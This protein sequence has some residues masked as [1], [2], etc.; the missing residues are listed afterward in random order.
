MDIKKKL[1]IITGFLGAGKTTF[2]NRLPEIFPYEKYA[3]IINEFGDKSVDHSL[4]KDNNINISKVT[5]GSIFCV[6]RQDK[7]VDAL[8]ALSKTDSKF[9]F[10]ET[11]GM[12]D[13]LKMEKILITAQKL[14]NNA[15]LYSGCISIADSVSFLKVYH[16]LNAVKN[17]IISADAVLINKS[18]L[19]DESS[20]IEIEK[21]ILSLNPL[22]KV[23]R[24]NFCVPDDNSILIN[25]EHKNTK[26]NYIDLSSD[27]YRSFT[28]ILDNSLP[29]DKFKKWT[30]LILKYAFRIKGFAVLDN[31]I[32]LIDCIP[33]IINI[34][35]LN[36]EIINKF[37]II[38]HDGK[39]PLINIAKNE[40]YN[41]FN[42]NLNVNKPETSSL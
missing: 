41:I 7:F 33:D 35:K 4:I 42:S 8:I 29:L 11:S 15:Y 21:K 13:T 18:A 40:F 19:T 26:R 12:S 23:S 38:I 36:E 10:V 24:A 16:T 17:Q 3:V 20:L 14:S 31:E 32:Q 25:L 28:I 6:C 37:L 9:V 30:A 2:I 39:T 1:Y 22:V 34:K 27:I 5:N